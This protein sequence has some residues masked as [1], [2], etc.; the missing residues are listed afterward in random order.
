MTPHAGVMRG[1]AVNDLSSLWHICAA[2]TLPPDRTISP[3]FLAIN[4]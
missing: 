3:E 4:S 2:A 1:F